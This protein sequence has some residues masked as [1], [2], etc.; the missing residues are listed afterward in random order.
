MCAEVL[1]ALLSADQPR[2][3]LKESDG[4][5]DAIQ[6][7]DQEGEAARDTAQPYLSSSLLALV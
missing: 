4:E 7:S 1:V 5:E 6:D 2:R 3:A